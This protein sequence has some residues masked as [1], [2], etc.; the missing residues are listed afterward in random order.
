MEIN[1]KEVQKQ[2]NEVVAENER[3]TYIKGRYNELAEKIRN[4][5]ENIEEILD[6]L[7]KIADELS[8]R[9]AKTKAKR[10][11]TASISGGIAQKIHDKILSEG[12]IYSVD[13]VR[14]EFPNQSDSDYGNIMSCLKKFTDLK[15]EKVG[16][17]LR[18]FV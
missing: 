14:K 2:I 3:L 6:S 15:R 11:G 17:K 4:E 18:F 1:L 5:V 10:D 13:E 16:V 7:N 8:P 12:K 9:F